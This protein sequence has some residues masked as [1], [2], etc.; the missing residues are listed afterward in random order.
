[1]KLRDSKYGCTSTSIC[2]LQQLCCTMIHGYSSHFPKSARMNPTR[3]VKV[4]WLGQ[5]FSVFTRN[6]R[7]LTTESLKKSHNLFFYE[8]SV[9]SIHPG[10]RSFLFPSGISDKIFYVFLSSSLHSTFPLRQQIAPT[11][12]SITNVTMGWYWM[13]FAHFHSER[14]SYI[15]QRS[16]H[17]KFSLSCDP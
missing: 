8:M 10:I 4:F 12:W 14:S 13:W 15:I 7:L 3:Q 2:L 1:M 16:E 9:F 17:L 6:F 11:D 5:E